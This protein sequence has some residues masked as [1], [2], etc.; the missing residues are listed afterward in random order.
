MKTPPGLH[1]KIAEWIFERREAVSAYLFGV[2]KC[3]LIQG[4][5]P[6]NRTK[7]LRLEHLSILIYV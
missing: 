3:H 5:K 7:Y 4:I 6:K 2:G 1:L